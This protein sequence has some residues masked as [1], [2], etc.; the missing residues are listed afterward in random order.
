MG[1][2]EDVAELKELL[3]KETEIKE[4]KFKFP[5]GKKVTKAQKKKGFVTVQTISENANVDFKK[6]KI[7]NQTITHD[8]IP[9]LATAGHVLQYNNNPLII[10]PEWSVKPI[11]PLDLYISSLN[12]G[13]NTKGYKILMDAM[14][15][16]KVTEKPKMGGWVKW[17]VGLLLAGI[18]IYAIMTG[19]GH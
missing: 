3:K 17:V 10:L 7:E 13:S 14:Y 18:I 15:R 4:K 2:Q 11:S 19:G 5:F 9:R 8:L 1:I 6:Y 12:D 16:N